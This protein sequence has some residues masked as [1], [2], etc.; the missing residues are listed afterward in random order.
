MYQNVLN[1]KLLAKLRSISFLIVILQQ[2]IQFR[3]AFGIAHAFMNIFARKSQKPFE[4]E[5]TFI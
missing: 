1:N 2:H 4:K 5:H 3:K